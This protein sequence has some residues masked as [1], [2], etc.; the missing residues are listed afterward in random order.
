MGQK[1]TQAECANFSQHSE[2]VSD[3]S[4]LA[5]EIIFIIQIFEYFFDPAEGKVNHVLF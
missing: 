3:K 5:T 2:F 4:G 1:K